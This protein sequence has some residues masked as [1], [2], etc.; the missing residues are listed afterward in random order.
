M[1]KMKEVCQMT[2]LT[3]KAVCIWNDCWYP[4]ISYVTED[5]QVHTATVRYGGFKKVGQQEK[6]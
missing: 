2:G 4:V 1:Y 6:N 3:E 5:G